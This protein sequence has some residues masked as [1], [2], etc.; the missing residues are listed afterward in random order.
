MAA[1]RS[2]LQKSVFQQDGER[3]LAVASVKKDAKR[4]KELY[5]CLVG[6]FIKN[7]ENE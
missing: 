4:K 7:G 1:L 2:S 6:Q 5:M 3:L